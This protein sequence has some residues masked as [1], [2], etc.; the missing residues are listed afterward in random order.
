MNTRKCSLMQCARKGGVY[1]CYGDGSWRGRGNAKPRARDRVA[2]EQKIVARW[3]THNIEGGE[4]GVALWIRHYSLR[5]LLPTYRPTLLPGSAYAR[6]TRTVTRTHAY[7][8]SLKERAWLN[9]RLR[10]VTLWAAEE[11]RIEKMYVGRNREKK[12]R[13]E[14]NSEPTGTFWMNV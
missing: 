7:A 8:Y 13:K 11:K 3:E 9:S 14:K 4:S 1:I 5:L 2:K 12:K 10:A 6:N